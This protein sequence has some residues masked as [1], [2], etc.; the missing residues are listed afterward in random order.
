MLCW[1][2]GGWWWMNL[3]GGGVGTDTNRKFYFTGMQMQ[4]QADEHRA[5][6]AEETWK[7]Q[8]LRPSSRRR[9]RAFLLVQV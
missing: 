9:T 2:V 4:Q 5:I 6:R 8:G 7:E 1:N 3:S